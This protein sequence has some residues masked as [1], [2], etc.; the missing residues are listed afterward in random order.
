MIL[1]VI[2]W[3]GAGAFAALVLGTVGS[4]VFLRSFEQD[5]DGLEGVATPSSL[6][7]DSVAG[8][9]D[10]YIADPE[11]NHPVKHDFSFEEAFAPT[12]AL[13]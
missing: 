6:Y 5:T 3:V 10:D 11:Y 1:R 7:S 9:F 4:R 12:S 8:D 2:G 13:T